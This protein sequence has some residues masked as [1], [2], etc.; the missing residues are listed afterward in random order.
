MSCIVSLTSLD[1]VLAE[2]CGAAAKENG[3]K[4]K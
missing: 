2:I 4:K 1:A 3:Q